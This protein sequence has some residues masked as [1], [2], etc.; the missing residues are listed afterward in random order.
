M[1]PRTVVN[2]SL[3]PQTQTGYRQ[4]V[5]GAQVVDETQAKLVSCDYSVM[6]GWDVERFHSRLRR[7]ELIEQTPFSRFA[8]KT[9]GSGQAD[10]TNT[11]ANP[12]VHYWFDPQW[13]WSSSTVS[14]TFLETFLGTLG[15]DGGPYV[16][17]AAARIYSNGFDALTFL[18]ELKKTVRL[19]TRA[20]Q[21][22]QGLL[23]K[24]EISKTW[25][26][27]RYGWRILYYELVDISHALDSLDSKRK[28]YSETCG[29]SRTGASTSS[30][31]VS[32]ASFNATLN[33]VVSWK[34]SIR[35]N[36]VADIEPPTFEFNPI[37]TAWELIPYSFVV[38]WFFKIGQW[39]AS[40]S[41]LAYQSN[42]VASVGYKL[43]YTNRV[44]LSAVS[45]KAGWTVQDARSDYTT[46]VSLTNRA[47]T[48]V[49]FR[50]STNFEVPEALK[51][52]DLLALIRQALRR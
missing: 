6:D 1:I 42:Y 31:A 23:A 45:P 10:R 40:M 35:G 32:S 50:L 28:R 15:V 2:G 7:G 39:L 37:T 14:R 9:S 3:T 5:G 11:A 8:N 24:G 27:Y 18:A 38:D 12:D 34:L 51:I 33:T 16:Q 30:T 29:G 36:V 47:P 20:G 41:F 19:F 21:T 46:V 22:F 25:L 52:L 4:P 13:A 48:S 44:Y 26:Q 17:A 49:P 43:E